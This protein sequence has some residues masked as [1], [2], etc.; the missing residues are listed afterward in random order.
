MM[1]NANNSSRLRNDLTAGS[2]PQEHDHPREGGSRY[3][4]FST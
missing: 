2:Q 4:I 1:S 3:D